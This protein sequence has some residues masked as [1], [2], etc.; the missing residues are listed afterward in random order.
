MIRSRRYHTC[1][2]CLQLQ[3]YLLVSTLPLLVKSKS[4]PLPLQY[5]PNE[6]RSQGEADLEPTYKPAESFLR[7][8]FGNIKSLMHFN[9]L[10][11]INFEKIHFNLTSYTF[12]K[13]K[14]LECLLY[15]SISHICNNMYGSTHFVK[16]L[17]QWYISF[18]T[19]SFI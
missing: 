2:L 5:E 10:D 6:S 3:S 8:V 14:N 12:L 13:K 11:W 18:M 16:V 15:K 1:V 7:Y 17:V 19:S 4:V 9:L